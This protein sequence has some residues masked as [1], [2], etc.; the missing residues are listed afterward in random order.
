MR[1]SDRMINLMEKSLPIQRR[2]FIGGLVACGCAMTSAHALERAS[3]RI[4]C[5]T[6]SS[7]QQAPFDPGYKP[8]TGIK[9]Y[10][11]AVRNAL[12][13]V[14]QATGR[15]I[16]AR[17][18]FTNETNALFDPRNNVIAFG[19][20]FLDELQ[21]GDFKLKVL[22]IA[23]H[24]A[25]HIIQVEDDRL[26]DGYFDVAVADKTI[27][28][29]ELMADSFAGCCLAFV[30]NGGRRIDRGLIDRKKSSVLSAFQL[31]AQRGDAYFTNPNHHGTAKE[32]FEAVESGYDDA[33]EVAGGN[34][35][36]D[37]SEAVMDRARFAVMRMQRGG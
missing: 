37:I 20:A 5:Y 35:T 14:S 12:S 23:A 22:C 10:D 1:V 24:E 19:K 9:Q 17:L 15:P 8:S 3:S 29:N 11:D 27:R 26:G 33:F 30:V 34:P 13:L 28:R 6:I 32:R 31:M 36:G 25:A 18:A 4:G 2:H 21:G 16:N 7:D